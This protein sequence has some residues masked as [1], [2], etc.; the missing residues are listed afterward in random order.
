MSTSL[1][2]KR[3]MVILIVLSMSLCFGEKAFGVAIV[4]KTLEAGGKE[5][6]SSPADEATEWQ[7]SI[8]PFS[9]DGNLNDI[10]RDAS[11][12]EDWQALRSENH[13]I[14]FSI[15]DVDRFIPFDEY[16]TEF[17]GDDFLLFLSVLMVSIMIGTVAGWQFHHARRKQKKWAHA[18]HK[19]WREST[20]KE[21][22]PA[23]FSYD[24]FHSSDLAD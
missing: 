18:I 9:L 5:L 7:W 6:F 2:T 21:P 10:M 8:S 24:S 19:K 3:N 4:G 14:Y 16:E 1:E 23:D 13:Q 20:G 15:A 17:T 11:N 12:K 22:V